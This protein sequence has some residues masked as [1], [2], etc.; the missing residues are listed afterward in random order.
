MRIRV[1][2]NSGQL[3]TQIIIVNE[4]WLKELGKGVKI[5]KPR[6]GVVV[7]RTPTNEVQLLEDKGGEHCQGYAR[8]RFLSSKGFHIEEIA[9]LKKR[10]TSRCSGATW[11]MV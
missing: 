4:Q 7:H 5:A 2:G 10:L 1:R 8:E 9:W 6:F 11:N 3:R